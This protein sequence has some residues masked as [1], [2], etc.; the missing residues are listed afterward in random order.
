MT[1]EQKAR[2]EIDRQ[3]AQCDWVVQSFSEMNISAGLGVAV[4][5][6]PHK[7]GHADYLPYADCKPPLPPVPGL[8]LPR[9]PET[10]KKVG[11]NEPC[12]CGSGKKFKN[13]CMK[14]QSGF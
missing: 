4:R 3:L 10:K 2:Q 14:K 5:E 1:P 6:F 7:R 9:K 12:P 8:T 11:R 13:C